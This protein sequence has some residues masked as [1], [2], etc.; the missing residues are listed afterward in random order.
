MVLSVKKE[1]PTPLHHRKRHGHHHKRN[2][3]YEKHYWPYLPLLAVAGFGFV[4]NILWTPISH[5]IISHDVLGYATNTSI[6]GLL[7]ETNA[8][9]SGNGVASLRL[10]SQLN[11]AAQAKADDMADRNYWSHTTPEGKEPWWFID[12]AGY[13]YSTVG[14]NLAYGFSSSSTTVAGWMNSPGHKANLLNITFQDVGFGIAQSADYVSS[15]PQTI[16][17][18]MYGKTSASAPVSPSQ[19]PQPTAP[20]TTSTPAPIPSVATPS[21]Q[22]SP[23]QTAPVSP[24]PTTGTTEGTPPSQTTPVV[25]GAT[26]GSQRVTRLQTVASSV[27]AESIVGV[28]VAVAAAAG[29]FI[30]RHTRAL[31]RKLVKG[32]RFI[33]R[34]VA[35]DVVFVAVIVLGVV[36]TRTA[37]FIN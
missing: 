12:T 21:I 24:S 15:G 16:I 7:D 29:L 34:H 5:S 13:P 26:T 8:Q 22:S 33:I 6:V 36:L 32:E 3:Q 25:A 28:I 37:G 4:F 14:E 27:P 35:L 1:K 19:Q 18:A 30:F 11:Q 10:N 20:S 9:R 23:S 31:H 17:V 2:K